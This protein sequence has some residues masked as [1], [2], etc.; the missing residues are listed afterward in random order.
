MKTVHKA[1]KNMHLESRELLAHDNVHVFPSGN[2]RRKEVM[3][4]AK[5]DCDHDAHQT[6]SASPRLLRSMSM[7]NTQSSMIDQTAERCPPQPNA[8]TITF[9]T[10]LRL[11][12]QIK[13]KPIFRS[14][15]QPF[16]GT[17]INN[18]TSVTSNVMPEINNVVDTSIS[19]GLYLIGRSGCLW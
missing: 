1:N 3:Y 15:F 19:Y 6:N 7:P 11:H 12:R 10:V 5:T 17:T 2:Q 16:N 8:S 14:I 18:P 4:H 13:P 9:P